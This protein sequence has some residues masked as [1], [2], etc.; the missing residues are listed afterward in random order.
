MLH[1]LVDSAAAC[2]KNVFER[3]LFFSLVSIFFFVIFVAL[4]KLEIWKINW[5]F[6]IR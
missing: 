5:L 2:V 3:I 1:S 4:I 6:T